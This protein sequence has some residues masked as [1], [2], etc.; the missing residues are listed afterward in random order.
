MPSVVEVSRGHLIESRH[1]VSAAV[2]R[3]DGTM[4]ASTG[5]PGY[6][7]IRAMIVAGQK[8]LNDDNTRFDMTNFKPR[9]DWVREM[10]RYGVL[11]ECVKPGEVADVY[12]IEQD[13]WKSLWHQ[14]ATAAASLYVHGK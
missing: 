8:F 2:M 1:R 12:A 10:K 14:P 13:Y 5:D 9:A 6:Q 3:A 7:A 4:F 11:P